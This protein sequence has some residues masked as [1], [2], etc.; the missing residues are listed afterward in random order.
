MK[1]I[2]KLYLFVHPMPYREK[3]RQDYMAKW[4]DLLASEGSDEANAICILSNAARGME[5]LQGLALKSFGE[6][7]VI[8]PDDRSAE[9]K[10]R[11]AEDLERT[12]SGRGSKREWIP[13]EIWTSNNARRWTEGLKKSMEERGFTCAP[14]RLQLVTCGQEW[15][16]CLTKYSAFM[17]KY[18]G[19]TQAADV[20]AD[21]SPDAGF[22]IQATFAERVEMERHVYLFLFRMPDGRPMGQF[23]DGLRGVWE[24]PHVATVPVDP[25]QVEIVTTSPNG[26]LKVD[27]AAK[28]TPEG[29][30]ADVGDGCHPATTTLIGNEMGY[31]AFRSSLR[32]ARITP[33]NDRCVM[34]YN[35]IGYLNPMT[36]YRAEAQDVP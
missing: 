29:V 2:Q 34:Q 14:E 23:M 13:Y 17:G 7:C 15:G 24:P 28:V 5:D 8:D 16:G 6:R 12:L 32:E 27:E 30:V 26:A 1:Q 25:K 3:T 18:L 9:T 11:I 31:E 10:V 36:T 4:K 22:P 33:R 35:M 20:R 21:L 19:L